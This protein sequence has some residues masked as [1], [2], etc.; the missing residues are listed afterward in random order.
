[1]SNL[2]RFRGPFAILLGLLLAAAMVWGQ[3]E[4]GQ[5]SGTI[6]DASGAVVPNVSVTAKNVSTGVQRA[7]TTNT[8]GVYVIPN[9]APGEWE[10]TL[11][12]SGF[13]SQKKLV[14]VDVGNKVTLDARMEVGQTSTTV[15]VSA[16]AVQVNTESQTL[17]NTISNQQVTEL[18]SLTRNPYDFVAT[19]PNV[20]GDSNSGRGTGYAINGMRSS[21][22]NVMLDGV[23]NND[24]FTAT[25]GQQVPVDA[26]QEYAVTTSSFTA[27]YGRASGGVVNVITKSGTN[28][29]HGSAYEF[30]RLSA[31]ASNSFYDNANELPKGIYTRN[32]FGYSVGGPII[33]NK[34]FFFQNTEWTRV[35]SYANEVS[36]VPTAQLIA[37]AAS[38]TQSFFSAYGKLRSDLTTLATYTKAD[39]GSVCNASGP[40]ASLPSTTPMFSEVAYRTPADAGGGSPQNTYDLVGNVDF[41]ASEKMQMSFKYAL[42][43]EL[44][45]PGVVNTSPY[46][47][48]E[49]GQ[50]NVD[51]HFT[52]SLTRTFSPTLVSQTRLSFNRLNGPN[53]PLGTAP[54]GP[55]LYMNSG[56][57]V[58][59][60][61]N[62]QLIAFP[63][64]NEY[65]PGSAIP[66]GGPQNFVVLT[67]DV[68]K[69][70]G[71]HNIRFGG[72]VTYMQD[73]RTFGAYEEAVESLGTNTGN[74]LDGFLNGQLHGFQAAI[75]PQGQYPGGTV[76]LPV[77]PPNFSR[78]N[79]YNEFALYGQD[80][81]KVTPRLTVNFGLRW[82]YFGVQ[83]NKDPKLDSNIVLGSGDIYHEIQGA[84]VQPT[85][86]NPNGGLWHK[87]YKDF[88][89]RVGFAYALTADGKTSLRGGYGIGYERNFGNVTFNIIQ[90]PPN[91]AVVS[92]IA[93]SDLAQ[94]PISV[95]NAGPL[96]GSTGSKKLPAVSLRA[97][98]P[99]IKEA[100]AHTMS[101]SL[102]RQVTNNVLASIE[103]SGS[104]GERLYSIDH[105]NLNGYGTEYL[106]TPC[107]ALPCLSR[108]NT[109]YSNI[110]MRAGGGNSDYN[111]LVGQLT[112]KDVAHSGVTLQA[113]YTWS[114]ALD[115]LS[116]T[117]SDGL[118][119]N[120]QLGFMDPFSPMLDH[121]NSDFDAT[122]RVAISAI[123][124]VPVFKGNSL[125]DRML[126]G[127]ELAPIFTAATGNPY[128]IYDC[129]NAY[130]YCI[131]AQQV[132][133]TPPK[134]VT[135]VP[136]PGAA[137]N[138]EYYQFT[139]FATGDLSWYNPKIGISDV[140]P[141]PNNITAR[142][143]FRA[144]GSFNVNLGVYKNTR[145]TEKATLQLRLEMY[146]ALNHATFFVYGVDA[147]VEGPWVD[148]YRDGH[149]DVQLGA[150][151]T[152]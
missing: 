97:V 57:A 103:Y 8:A 21:S 152:F 129:T 14:K 137:D 130:A 73:N 60:N 1:M 30:N 123:W 112:F 150:K 7:S 19:V 34:L 135:N 145:L 118:Q 47:G 80:S 5:I 148:G 20:S 50:T 28:S 45:F 35:R 65:T 77:G 88:S 116:S 39:L 4:T 33:K 86:T 27:E 124:S 83:H 121:G 66:F 136:T 18:P 64:Y 41:N 72:Q 54:I 138:Y 69:V 74:S 15:E 29:F 95:D 110:N 25:V 134:G 114:H 81:F 48:Y 125:R 109:Q 104:R 51:N 85:P 126:G 133:P 52:Y 3:V 11:S 10:V 90:N 140:G 23:A 149:R 68:T 36:N 87:D 105:Y 58:R 151:L 141:F 101:L 92:L 142:N 117:F 84:T 26:V 147:E 107:S 128:S 40:C 131:R 76:T 63:G 31:L 91:Y 106:G 94:I 75:N 2:K 13:A 56:A 6:Q 146:N 98:D 108:M 115:D 12:A 38:N 32:N 9:V 67:Q 71:R 144:P 120:Y 143:T 24:E 49:T 53:Q 55:T 79:R 42:Y 100:Y 96:A 43:N 122:H 37:A 16:G 132:G 44:D 99:N 89:P 82:E 59:L 17:S 46:Q 22:T 127:W 139:N 70:R 102:E 111:A 78:S 119:G 61:V 113:N 62:G 93:G